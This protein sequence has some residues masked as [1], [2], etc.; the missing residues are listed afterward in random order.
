MQIKRSRALEPRKDH[1]LELKPPA[2]FGCGNLF[3]RDNWH[4]DVHGVSL[5]RLK[6][7]FGRRHRCTSKA[8]TVK[9]VNGIKK[10]D[11]VQ[12]FQFV[13]TCFCST[14]VSSKVLLNLKA[15]FYEFT[16]RAPVQWDSTW[17]LDDKRNRVTNRQRNLPEG[18]CLR[19]HDGNQQWV[20]ASVTP[21]STL[22]KKISSKNI[23]SDSSSIS[24]TPTFFSHHRHHV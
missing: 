7:V 5:S 15:T 4:T 11:C 24:L 21:S 3:L 1:L 23:V 6:E 22:S 8:N 19:F 20:N 17:T 13:G 2:L 12:Y 14:Y 18:T 10:I 16:K 9:A